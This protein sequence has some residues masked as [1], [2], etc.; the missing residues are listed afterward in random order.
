[1]M[2]EM[3]SLIGNFTKALANLQ[4]TLLSLVSVYLRWLR[5]SW[6]TTDGDTNIKCEMKKKLIAIITIVGSQYCGLPMIIL[7]VW[8]IPNVWKNNRNKIRVCQLRYLII[9]WSR[10]I[11]IVII[12]GIKIT[13]LTSVKLLDTAIAAVLDG[14]ANVK[15][16][17]IQ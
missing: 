8:I 2:N 15:F 9:S 12:T 6:N 1:M 14:C 16:G 10:L 3:M 5:R 11:T 17:I 13:E 7:N 4:Y